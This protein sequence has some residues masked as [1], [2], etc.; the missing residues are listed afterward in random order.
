[1]PDKKLSNASD[2]SRELRARAEKHLQQ[3]NLSTG[4][5]AL[6]TSSTPEEMQRFIH[7]LTV[8][9]IELEM[10][11]EELA[12]SRIELEASLDRYTELYDFAPLGYLTID[13]SSKILAANLTATNML[14]VARS[15]LLGIPLKLFFV[16]EDYVVVDAFIDKLFRER[17]PGYCIVSFVTDTSDLCQGPNLLA[18]HT[19]RIDASKVETEFTFNIILSDITEQRKAAESSLKRSEDRYRSLFDNM[20]NGIAYCR[21]IYEDDRPVDFIYEQVNSSF[22][23]QIGLKHVEGKKASEVIP[24]IH[25]EHPEL[26]EIYGRVA[27]SGQP[28]RFEL[29]LEVL[30]MWFVISAYSLQKDHFVAVFEN[31]TDRKLLENE[32]KKLRVAVEQAPAIVV[33]TDQKGDIEYVNPMFTTSTGYTAEEAIGQNPRILKS[34]LMPDSVYLDMWQTIL[35]GRIWDGEL[36]NK[37]KNGE[38][39]WD[40][41]VISAIRNEEGVI[42]NFVAVKLEITEQKK[43]LNDLIKAREKAEENDRLKSAFLANISHEIR[44]PMNGILGFS[45]L[46]KESHL[47]GEEQA[48]YIDLIYRSG[49]RMLKLIN[50]LI[51][52]SR[53]EAGETMVQ[54]TETPVNVLLRDLDAF[55]KPQA[56]SKK[57]SL[58]VVTALPDNESIIVTD[59]AKLNQILTNL[60]QNALKFTLKGG[61]DVGYTRQSDMLEFYVSDSGIGIP[62][63]MQLMIFDRFRQVN[64]TLTRTQQGSGLGLSIS[65]SYVAM[66]GG[67]I[68]V[69]SVEGKGSKFSF[70]LPYKPAHELDIAQQPHPVAEN[71]AEAVRDITVLI[72]E[73][74]AMS[75]ILLTRN[76]KSADITILTAINGEKAVEQVRQHPE[77]DL[78][79]MDI[80][81]PVMNG[82]D[83][84]RLIKEQRPGLPIIVQSAFTSKEDKIKATEAGADSFITKPINKTELLQ[85]VAKL[86]KR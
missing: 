37:K 50:D 36:H 76:L 12:R 83:A 6:S 57:L 25:T 14:G 75:T 52:I 27:T 29:Y 74:D 38:L 24:G 66:L 77:I 47:T 18:G 46:L 64:N 54:I 45:Q 44:T 3:K 69:E 63:D 43:L 16:P 72:V 79:L 35:S 22:E 41:A 49:Q 65:K 59:A 32:L 40:Q 67:T 4:S 2:A 85:L 42:T 73:D 82:F 8:H 56:D 19:L 17:M 23:K 81:M 80:K 28:E 55:F 84:T 86:L 1:M 13:Q 26:L 15:Q 20:L 60:V 33:I 5:S 10:Q 62:Q 71:L 30:G 68:K 34:G 31:I 51:D 70:T 9:Q 39:Y 61:I 48:E 78:V 58:Q 21:M 11:R 53:I 7:E